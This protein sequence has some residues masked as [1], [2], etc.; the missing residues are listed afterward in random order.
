MTPQQIIDLDNSPFQWIDFEHELDECKAP[1]PSESDDSD[2]DD[3]DYTDSMSLFSTSSRTSTSPATN[4]LC[5]GLAVQAV[6]FSL[7]TK[8]LLKS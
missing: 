2:E 7:Q 4:M 1:P 6:V 8:S 5:V 3:S